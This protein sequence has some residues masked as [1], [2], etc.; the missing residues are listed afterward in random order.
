MEAE[1]SSLKKPVVF[2]DIDGTLTMDPLWLFGDN[3]LGGFLWRLAKKTGYDKRLIKRAKPNLEIL[4]V[5]EWLYNQG[6]KII[7][8]TGRPTYRKAETEE[9]L[10][11]YCVHYTWLYCRPRGVFSGEHKLG[12]IREY[13]RRHIRLFYVDDSTEDLLYVLRGLVEDFWMRGEEFPLCIPT[14]PKNWKLVK[15]TVSL[16]ME[17]YWKY[18]GGDNHANH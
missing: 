17:C 1:S 4:R 14:R 3:R 7:L 8:V 11:N 18:L 10:S 16:T 13:H 15:D 9:W 12:V 2:L 6:V 5:V